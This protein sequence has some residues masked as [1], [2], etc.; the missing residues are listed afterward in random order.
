MAGGESACTR[1]PVS[2]TRASADTE[3]ASHEM[4]HEYWVC[5]PDGYQTVARW[6][7]DMR[8]GPTLWISTQRVDRLCSRRAELDADA[9]LSG[10]REMK[11]FCSNYNLSRYHISTIHA[12]FCSCDQL[13]SNIQTLT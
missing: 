9:F 12:A 5:K 8:W 2:V 11:A 4:A 7:L 6:E 1:L 10:R 13:D 3:F